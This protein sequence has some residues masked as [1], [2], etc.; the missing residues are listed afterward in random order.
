MSELSTT[1]RVYVEAGLAAGSDVVL[2]ADESHYLI[3]V[4]RRKAGDALRLFNGRDGEWAATV[5][6][7]DKRACRLSIREQTRRQ[8]AV[9]D[10]WLCF[11]P[12]KKTPTD[13]LV[14]KAT[15]LGVRRLQP[16]LTDRT[17]NRRV[18]IVRLAEVAR[19][20]AEQ[21]E[22]LEVPEIVE[23]SPLATLLANWP[24]DRTLFFLDEA[25]DARPLAEQAT[26]H[27]GTPS[28]LIIGPE[29]GFTP[30]ER[31]MLLD[32][33]ASVPCSLGPRLLRAE[34]A[35]A[36]ALAIW[37]SVAGDLAP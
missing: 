7:A 13:F 9:P 11:A 27:I 30:D 19:E 32:H 33:A 28:A 4:M 37:Q 25:R 22:C 35:A 16:V 26:K 23:P 6:E 36:A 8:A 14:E 2:G 31:R 20:A 29:G 18:N 5:A 12:I 10:I 21:C 15:E 17:E 24:K 34:T 1:P 3:R